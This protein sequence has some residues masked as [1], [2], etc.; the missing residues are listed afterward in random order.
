MLPKGSAKYTDAC[1]GGPRRRGAVDGYA[2]LAQ[3][4][5]ECVEL[6]V[7]DREREVRVRRR[8]GR[9]A[10]ALE[11]EVDLGRVV[12]A[13]L[14]VVGALVGVG[15]FDALGPVSEQLLATE[16]AEQRG[17]EQA[18]VERLGP[19]EVVHGQRE[20]VDHVD[21]GSGAGQ[22]RVGLGHVDVMFRHDLHA[23]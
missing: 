21:A 10:A 9:E 5:R 23:Q 18:D 12:E 15:F 11:E 20:V 7:I 6:V 19:G 1:P 4:R 22:G 2:C 14:D 13:D 16:A 3:A 8:R 17:A